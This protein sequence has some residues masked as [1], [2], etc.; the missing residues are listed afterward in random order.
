MIHYICLRYLR[1][2]TIAT[3][4]LHGIIFSVAHITTLTKI[5]NKKTY[6]SRT[7][8]FVEL[9]FCLLETLQT[10]RAKHLM[11][12]VYFEQKQHSSVFEHQILPPK[13][14]RVHSLASPLPLTLKYQ[15]VVY[16]RVHLVHY[17]RDAFGRNP[18]L[19]LS[20]YCC[21]ETRKMR[22]RHL[23]MSR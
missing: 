13:G 6:S 14:Y 9:P 20:S 10:V 3:L 23:V 16:D 22:W 17:L 12:I 5:P 15:K 1:H 19:L 4:L 11:N 2:Y 21:L 8:L 18:P 7:Y